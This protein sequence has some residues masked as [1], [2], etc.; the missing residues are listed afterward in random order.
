MP[1]RSILGTHLI[2][3][4]KG[5]FPVEFECR[6]TCRIIPPVFSFAFYLKCPATRSFYRI[7]SRV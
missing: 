3:G 4:E 2:T 5:D 7:A 1:G 6:V